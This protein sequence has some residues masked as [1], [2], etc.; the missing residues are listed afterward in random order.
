[1]CDLWP[2]ERLLEE[3]VLEESSAGAEIEVKMY[4]IPKLHNPSEK[5]A[6]DLAETLA[7]LEDTTIF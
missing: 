3:R 5:I 7:G 1:M 2:D 4:D 6:Q